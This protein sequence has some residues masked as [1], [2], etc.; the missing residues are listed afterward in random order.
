MSK[1]DTTKKAAEKGAAENPATGAQTYG[2][3]LAYLRP[4]RAIFGASILGYLIFALTPAMLSEVAGEMVN[5][6]SDV[7]PEGKILVPLAIVG[8]YVLRGIGGF[9]GDY[10]IARVSLNVVH[11][12]RVELFS[13][14][15]T[16]PSDYF[17]NNNSGHL[18]SRI[19]YNVAQVT[20]SITSAIKVLIR[21][22][23]TVIFLF[24]Y[25]FW[26]DWQMTL[27]FL[28]IAPFIG[29]LVSVVGKRLKM[30]AAR[31]QVTMGD[32]TQSTSEMITGYKVMRSFGGEK[33]EN[34][35]F[36]DA[37]GNNK[38][39]G[40]KLAVT[41][42]TNT[43]VLQLIVAAALAFVVYL[44]MTLMNADNAGA[45]IAYVTAAGLIPK[46]IRQ[47][48]SVYGKIQKG[49]AAAEDIFL[50]LDVKAEPDTGEREVTRV[51][52][53]LEFKD[54]CFAYGGTDSDVLHSIN[55]KI[56]A[57]KTVALVGR[58]GSG[59][60][61]LASLL[62]RFYH[63][64]KGEILL[65]G[66]PVQSYALKSLR[67]QIALVNQEVT[68]FND[69]V[70]NNI[71]YGDLS[72]CSA[73]EV[74]EAAEAA[75]ALEFIEQMED[76]LETMVGEHGARLSGGQRQ[77]IAIARALLKNAPVL[78]LD[79]ATSALDTQSERKIQAALDHVM[80]GR[81]TLVIAHRLST[82]EKADIIVVMDAGRIV[83]Q[84]THAELI[85]KEGAYA[86][87]HALQFG[88]AEQT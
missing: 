67:Q 17:D 59:K 83:E 69:T 86:Q 15:T 27:V 30:L 56:P 20:E 46:P 21:E 49:I 80:E 13:G 68:L 11:D 52:G 29:L 58:S 81:T 64:F 82:I 75:Y 40:L 50:Q 35:R 25:L 61:T 12:L 38:K 63:N 31:I 16:L 60:T 34:D 76:G 18:I 53:E 22:G 28:A 32:I 26:K 88:E 39:Q 24:G 71:A 72:S 48:S 44:A 74:A 41:A 37:S 47:L 1:P 3:L 43:S 7:N 65:D 79:E 23:L 42:A 87:L 77:R 36:K 62:P 6:I 66:V 54:L 19:T 5:A 73:S 78:V 14:L 33:Y 4:Y 9:V 55:L 2:R 70:A 10:F 51:K 45:F 57:G 85:K 8:I 84:G